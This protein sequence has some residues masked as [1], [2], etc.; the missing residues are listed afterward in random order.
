M[1]AEAAGAAVGAGLQRVGGAVS[2]AAGAGFEVQRK[3]ALFEAEL[4]SI[5]NEKQ[6]IEAFEQAKQQAPEGADGFTDEIRER[7]DTWVPQALDEAP[8]THEAQQHIQRRL[9]SLRGRVLQGAAEFQA[10]SRAAL[11]T[12]RAGEALDGLTNYAR[13][14]PTERDATLQRFQEFAEMAPL[15]DDQTRAKFR[16]NGERQILAGALDG[17]VTRYETNP[18]PAEQVD[19]AISALKDGAFGFRDRV[20][21]Q[22]FDNALTRLERRK[23]TVAA[24]SRATFN[25]DMQ[26]TLAAIETNGKNP[27]LITKE[28]AQAMYPDNPELAER[29][30][31]Q[32]SEAE[33]AYEITSAATWDTPQESAEKLAQLKAQVAGRKAGETRDTYLAVYSALSKQWGQYEADKAS[34]VRKADKS[35]AEDLREAEGIEDPEERR[36]AFE[37][38]WDRMAELQTKKGTPY[39]RHEFLG[40]GAAA[41]VAEQMAGM[42]AEDAA[43]EMEKLSDKYGSRWPNVM[44]ELQ[45]AGVDPAIMAI[46]RLDGMNDVVTRKLAMEV[47]QAGVGEL[48]KVAGDAAAGIDYQVG[49]RTNDIVSVFSAGG[50]AGIEAI[51]GELRLIRGLAYKL[52]ASGETEA[53]AAEKAYNMVFGN[54]YDVDSDNLVPKGTRG[55]AERV[56]RDVLMSLTPA[57]FA[58]IAPGPGA[59]PIFEGTP[60]REEYRR[61]I[62][63][64]AAVRNGVWRNSPD[65]GGLVLFKQDDATGQGYSPALKADGTWIEIRFDEMRERA[66]EA[67][68]RQLRPNTGDLGTG[69]WVVGP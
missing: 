36:Q 19:A 66:V 16:D 56:Q 47:Q 67:R 59:D 21:P 9:E 38:A 13:A 48:R 39:W 29:A 35:L 44:R 54:K 46:A 25:M 68:E 62:A 2:E 28:R 49:K 57:D 8:A 17:W 53:D 50:R 45:A 30:L 55:M 33:K 12:R 61:R 10:A 34:Y 42:R 3:R 4:Q 22:T 14:N 18:V 1:S 41:V 23:K 69:A 43:N 26:A 20:K 27:G 63:Y 58:P 52:A 40:K 51:S 24:E 31:R 37:H 5:E 6:V 32:I 60:E 15:P 11:D 7:F 64:E 65:L